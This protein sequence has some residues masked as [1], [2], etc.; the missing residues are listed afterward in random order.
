MG[1]ESATIQTDLSH[2]GKSP[3]YRNAG[4]S[5]LCLPLANVHQTKKPGSR[6]GLSITDDVRSD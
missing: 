5:T 2:N 1:D 4:Q 6:A 3:G